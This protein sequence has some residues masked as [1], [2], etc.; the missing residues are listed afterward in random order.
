M[1]SKR[2]LILLLT[3]SNFMIELDRINNKNRIYLDII[4]YKL[5]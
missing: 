3:N 1:I 4:K 5:K 2:D